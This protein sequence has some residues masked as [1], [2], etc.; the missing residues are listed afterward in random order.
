MHERRSRRQLRAAVIDESV[1]RR[2]AIQQAL[3]DELQLKIVMTAGDARTLVS[4]LRRADRSRW[5]HLVA[6]SL[7]PDGGATEH[8]HIVA[9]L[10]GAGMRVL[11]L[12]SGASRSIGK[13]LHDDGIDGLLSHSDTRQELLTVAESV[14]A[15]RRTVS[16]AA[17][18]ETVRSPW[19]VRLSH[20]EERILALYASGL[21][22]A[23]AAAAIGVR[24][25]TARKY[26]A[27]VR[28]KYTAAGRPARSKIDL[29]RIAQDE[30]LI[31]QNP[32][33]GGR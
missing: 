26:L 5:P 9:A 23:E 17:E 8:S 27:R 30:G 16:P 31:E 7:P 24:H 28:D 29:A 25:D 3:G 4:W 2:E 22:V 12:T 33:R 13:R 11:A 21:T 20:Q 14:L 15:G 1:L 6:L 32:S 19:G 10:R 18:F